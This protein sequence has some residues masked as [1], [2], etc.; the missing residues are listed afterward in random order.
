MAP[1]KTEE[2]RDRSPR[3]SYRAEHTTEDR[4]AT[5]T[6]EQDAHA[7]VTK[8]QATLRIYGRYSRWCLFIG[9]VYYC[10][11]IVETSSR[12]LTTACVFV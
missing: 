3:R 8:V 4:G 2:S 6:R 9:Y 7:G 1:Q 5:A 12:S 10:F 11:T